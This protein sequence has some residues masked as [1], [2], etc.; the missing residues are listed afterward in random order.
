MRTEIEFK[1]KTDNSREALEGLEMALERALDKIGI[2]AEGHAKLYL[3]MSDAVDTGR[4]RNSI[5]H[6]TRTNVQS[7]HYSWGKS[8]KGRSVKAGSDSTTPRG[9]PEEKSIV[10]G[11]NVKYAPIIE[12]GKGGMA[13]RP[14]LK[15][16][17]LEHL[18]QYRSIIEK[19]MK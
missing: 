16:A 9:I 6:A 10:V 2:A 4:L 18:S 13:P 12:L 11:T 5:S 1:I 19:E 3:T 17:I 8:K 7:K 15:P 14:Y